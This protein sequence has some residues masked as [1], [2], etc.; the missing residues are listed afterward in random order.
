[1]NNLTDVGRRPLLYLYF[2]LGLSYE[3]SKTDGGCFEFRAL[4]KLFG[5]KW[6]EVREVCTIV[7]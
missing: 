7:I 3:E 4:K 5:P 2:S 6:G 1:M